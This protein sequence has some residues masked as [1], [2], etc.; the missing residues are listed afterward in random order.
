MTV[1][2]LDDPTSKAFWEFVDKSRQEWKE[3]QPSWSKDLE[4]REK[5]SS[6]TAQHDKD[7]KTATRP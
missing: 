6:G 2:K 5:S 1:K 3:Q 4:Q 7:C